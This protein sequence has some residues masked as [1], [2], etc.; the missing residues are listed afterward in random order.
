MRF[1]VRVLLAIAGLLGIGCA[2]RLT[3]METTTE[4][5]D[6]PRRSDA[7]ARSETPARRVD[8]PAP[9]VSSEAARS[10]PPAVTQAVQRDV[11]GATITSA[12]AQTA[13]G[14]AM[15]EIRA[16]ANGRTRELLVRADGVVL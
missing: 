3:P 9:A 4:V 12:T 11:P 1:N 10:L 6:E 2:S 14:A 8:Q 15:Y 5:S 13:G 7:P 16:N